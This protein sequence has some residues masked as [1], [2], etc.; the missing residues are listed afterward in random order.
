[1]FQKLTETALVF[2]FGIFFTLELTASQS[3]DNVSFTVIFDTEM[4]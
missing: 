1:M 2:T 4:C 3:E